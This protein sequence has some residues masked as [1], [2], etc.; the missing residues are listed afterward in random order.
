M[1]QP[2]VSQ[3]IKKL[4]QQLGAALLARY[5]KSFELTEAGQRLYDY[6]LNQAEAETQLRAIDRRR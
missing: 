1:T 6:A 3:H 5:G 4:E 2:G